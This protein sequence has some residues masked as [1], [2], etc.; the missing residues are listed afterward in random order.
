MIEEDELVILCQ[1]TPYT[2]TLLLGGAIGA[3]ITSGHQSH[4]IMSVGKSRIQ[5][6]D[7][8]KKTGKYLETK[9]EIKMFDVVKLKLNTFLSK[10]I[11]IKTA[12][13]KYNLITSKKFNGFEQKE[14]MEKVFDLL[15]TLVKK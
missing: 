7:V 15:K 2:S 8:D 14:S 11:M 5:L 12:A 4:Y 3:A 1:D 6:F 13:H 10:E 9:T